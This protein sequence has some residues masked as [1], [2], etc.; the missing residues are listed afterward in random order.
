MN[1]MYGIHYYKDDKNIIWVDAADTAKE[2]GLV[3]E[4]KSGNRAGESFI[5]WN[6]MNQ[7]IKSVGELSNNDIAA[8]SDGNMVTIDCGP[9]GINTIKYPVRSG[10][11]IPSMLAFLVAMKADSKKAREFQRTLLYLIDYVNKQGVITGNPMLDM[12]SNLL[13]ESPTY[14]TKRNIINSNVRKYARA[15]KLTFGQ[16]FNKLYETMENIYGINIKARA[17]NYAKKHGYKDYS[18]CKYLED[19]NLLDEAARA[20]YLIMYEDGRYREFGI[21]APFFDNPQPIQPIVN[22]N[23][24]NQKDDMDDGYYH[25]MKLVASVSRTH[26][27]IKVTCETYRDDNGNTKFITNKIKI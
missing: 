7:Y 2:I 12:R 8:R 27:G 5:R 9:D 10:D 20:S 1:E 25:P 15:N 16:A 6:R 3:D 24:N 26:D 23:I 4:R 21:P 19:N 14:G 17:N 11:C 18:Y 13:E 22:V